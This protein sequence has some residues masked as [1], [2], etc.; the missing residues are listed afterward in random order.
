MAV[1]KKLHDDDDDDDDETIFCA[2][3]CRGILG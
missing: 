3:F 1:V 2:I